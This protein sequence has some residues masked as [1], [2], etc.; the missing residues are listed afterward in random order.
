MKGNRFQ[1]LRLRV[2]PAD[3]GVN[4]SPVKIDENSYSADTG[5]AGGRRARL[6]RCHKPSPAWRGD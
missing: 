4:A 1:H 3:E 5:R 2:A 6:L